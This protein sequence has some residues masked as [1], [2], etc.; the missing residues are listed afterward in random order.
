MSCERGL[1]E[2]REYIPVKA[3]A[4]KQNGTVDATAYAGACVSTIATG[5]A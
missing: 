1:D 4:T 3:D 2:G 5:G